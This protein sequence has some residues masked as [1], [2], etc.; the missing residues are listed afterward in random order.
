[1]YLIISPLAPVWLSHASVTVTYPL[2]FTLPSITS[3]WPAHASAIHHRRNQRGLYVERLSIHTP[4]QEERAREGPDQGA[5][6][7]GPP[8]PTFALSLSPFSCLLLAYRLPLNCLSFASLSYLCSLACLSLAS[9]L[10]LACLSLASRLPL[11][12]LLCASRLPLTCLPLTSRLPLACLTCLYPFR[13]CGTRASVTPSTAP[14]RCFPAHYSECS[15]PIDTCYTVVILLLHCC[16][17][18]VTRSLPC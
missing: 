8:G 17:T 16:Y 1:L 15:A 14:V 7:R 12:C 5:Q 18:A 10:P 4:S 9:R 11:A 13:P 6:L 2:H 3:V